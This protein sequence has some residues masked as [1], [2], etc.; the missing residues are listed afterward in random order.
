MSN[1]HTVRY[2][3]LHGVVQLWFNYRLTA[4]FQI[5]MCGKD[6]FISVA[7]RSCQEQ[8]RLSA[9]ARWTIARGERARA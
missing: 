8:C 4:S 5:Y 3:V 7:T 9:W 6:I 1:K 2:N